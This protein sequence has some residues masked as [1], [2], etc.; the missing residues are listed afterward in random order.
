MEEEEA[1]AETV[2]ED[3]DDDEFEWSD[4]DGPHPDETADQLRA[5]VESF[6]S[7]KKLPDDARAREE[8]QIRRAIELSLQAVDV[9]GCF[10]SVDRVGP[11]RAEVCRTAASFLSG[12]PKVYRTRGGRAHEIIVLKYIGEINH[13]ATGTAPSSMENYPSSWEQQRD[14]D[15]GGDGSGVDGEAFGASSPLRQGAGTETLS[16]HLGF[17]MAAARRFRVPWLLSSGFLG[18]DL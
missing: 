11:P 17:A 6:E 3:N 15:G 8:A 18:Q 10:Y 5:L 9:Y 14:E 13:I 16:P 7:E 2:V 12:L 1:D 4:D